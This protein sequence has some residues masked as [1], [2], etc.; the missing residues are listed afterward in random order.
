MGLSTDVIIVGGGVIGC[1]IAYALC[2]RGV[3]VI[4]MDQGAI[5]AQASTAASGML[6]PLKPFAKPDNPYT[7]L[8]LQSLALY[9]ALITELEDVSKVFIEY[10][11]T[12]S[13]RVVREKQLPRL[14]EWVAMWQALGYPLELVK[15][16]AIRDY[17]PGVTSTASV[18]LYNPYEPQLNPSQLVDAFACAA[19]K[20][21]AI[22]YPYQEV[23]A[24][25]SSGERITGIETSSGEH[26]ACH[27]L[28]V[29]TGAWAEPHG[30]WLGLTLPVRPLRAQSLALQ[31]PSIQLRHM[32]FGEKIYLAPKYNGTIIVG[33][34]RESVGFESQTTSEGIAWLYD[35]AKRLMPSL[36]AC[37][38]L[39]AW[40]GL[41]PNTPDTRPILGTTQAWQNV[42]LACGYNGFG[43]LL[44]ASTGDLIAD[45][46]LSG[47][48]PESLRS[49]MVDR[50]TQI[51]D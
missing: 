48:T 8:L 9:P 47:Q 35:A 46:V 1:S 33:V 40:A 41:L 6:A 42:T 24:F 32:L 10:Q 18:V 51:N 3:R 37:P 16:D 43:L 7:M 2:K 23:V 27:H 39:D 21:G 5:G 14:I 45:T 25:S 34:T 44:A 15:D 12:G 29:A 13:V 17:V 26:I 50:F 36:D 20:R 4:V 11:Q 28:V 22:F 19:E 49:F 31:Q 30:K 38:I